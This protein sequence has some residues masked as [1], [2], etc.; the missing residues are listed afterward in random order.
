MNAR[1]DLPIAASLALENAIRSLTAS[2]VNY[3]LAMYEFERAFIVW[4]LERHRGNQC[5]AAAEMGMHRNTIRRKIAELNIILRKD[6]ES[7]AA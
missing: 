7:E 6:K 1:Y 5:H 3:E 4:T 2:D